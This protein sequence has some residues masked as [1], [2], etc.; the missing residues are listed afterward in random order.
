M[1]VDDV[2][3]LRQRIL[4]TRDKEWSDE[5]ASFLVAELQNKDSGIRDAACSVLREN[6]EPEAAAL[7]VPLLAHEV[8]EVRNMASELLISF[9]PVSVPFL[10]QSFEDADGDTRKFIVDVLGLIRD[11]KAVPLLQKALDDPEPNV[12]VSAAEALGK[13]ADPAAVPA[14]IEHYHAVEGMEPVTIEAL[15]AIL[16]PEAEAFLLDLLAKESLFNCYTVLDALQN[17]ENTATAR[18]LYD[19]IFSYRDELKTDIL[20]TVFMILLK[21]DEALEIRESL[22]ELQDNFFE[23]LEDEDFSY[24]YELLRILPASFLERSPDRLLNL[25]ATADPDMAE[26]LDEKLQQCRKETVEML[27]HKISENDLPTPALVSLLRALIQHESDAAESLFSGLAE[28]DDAEVQLGLV[29]LVADHPTQGGIEVVTRLLDRA[30][31]IVQQAAYYVLSAHAE[32]VPSEVFEAGLESND[33]IIRE[34]SLEAIAR[35]NPEKMT[36]LVVS[37]LQDDDAEQILLA[38]KIVENHPGYVSCQSLFHLLEHDRADVRVA[39]V[40]ALS[41][42]DHEEVSS[43]LEFLLNDSEAPVRRAALQALA[44]LGREQVKPAV[45]AALNDPDVTVRI[46]GIEAIQRHSLEEFVPDLYELVVSD[47]RLLQIK[48]AQALLNLRG[49]NEA[50][51]I[52]EK[53]QQ[54]G[55]PVAFLKDLTESM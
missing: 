40:R 1:I 24:R 3:L 12:V 32:N 4:N 25:L 5:I 10:L 18:E 52:R 33:E 23:L 31:E 13:I 42:I 28:V 30:D 20:R 19:R 22:L 37:L 48:S 16:T 9:G 46:A 21:N 6:P 17:S 41:K 36:T 2:Q 50:D 11:R 47:Q 51:A 43:Q 26:V 44:Q 29:Q 54:H 34:Q 7:L 45:K 15:G 27:A 55:L 35:S 53:L 49:R 38:L 39:T 14:L 8:I